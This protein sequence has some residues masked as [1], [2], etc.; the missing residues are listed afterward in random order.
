MAQNTNLVWIIVRSILITCGV[1]GV[2]GLGAV[3]IT[4]SAIIGLVWFLMMVVLQFAAS[5]MIGGITY[6]RNAEAEFLAEQVLK[7]ASQMR[8]PYDLNC[9]YCNT[10][11]RV[12]VS[13]NSENVFECVNCKQPNKVYIQFSTV[14][15]TTPLSSK[16]S[17]EPYINMDGEDTGV[18][19]STINQPIVMNEK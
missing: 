3:V 15:L 6:K 8:I 9:A 18:S 14:R 12:G 16:S 5:Y 11:N 7:E 4:Q 1:A 10:L 13:F 19:Q 2:I 17:P